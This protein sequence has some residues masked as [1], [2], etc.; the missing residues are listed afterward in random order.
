MH[1]QKRVNDSVLWYMGELSSRVVAESGRACDRFH[2]GKLILRA[3]MDA[4]DYVLQIDGAT[5]ESETNRSVLE[6]STRC[7]SALRNFGLEPG[8]VMVLMA[9][10]HLD[11]A[12]PFY[13]ALYLGVVVSPVDRTLTVKELHNTFNVTR[14]KIVFCQ[15]EK[16][17]DIQLTLNQLDLNAEIV[18]FDKG[19]YLCNFQQFLEKYADGTAVKDFKPTDFDPEESLAVLIPTSG[20]TG[21]PKSAA[22]SHKN[23]VITNPYLWSKYIQFPTPTR[24]FMIGSP[25]Q[26]LTAIVNFLFSPILRYTRL[27]SSQNLTL[28]HACY[29]INRFKPS[30]SVF[31]PTL[32]TTLIRPDNAV[33]CDLTCFET[34]LLGGSAVPPSLI[35]ELKILTPGT[36][37][38][39]V[40][41]MTELTSLGFHSEAG[42][43]GACG[44]P[45]G[46][47]QYRIVNT[48]T[49]KDITE[50]NTLGE[51]WVK[52][53]GIFKGYYN[54]EEATEDTFA[55]DWFKTGDIFYRDEN[56]FFYFVERAKLMLKYKANQISPVELEVV[57]RQ[58]P[59]VSDVAVAG[60]PD[61]E[62]GDLPVACVVRRPGW[63]VTAQE[64]KDVVKNNL[65]DAKQL[66]GGVI[67]VKEL[68]MTASTKV[69]RRK[70]KEM[71]LELERE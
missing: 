17:P 64:I 32:M 11:L 7:A 47:F 12:I 41:G 54:N 58:H 13:A 43:P 42:P 34:I 35:D 26:W 8:D 18:T 40:Y 2:L 24:L 21:A 29:V 15:S 27:Q 45:V 57:I 14:P 25:L 9:P 36:D 23:F 63:A 37:V 5:N 68:P 70:L 30:Y 50:P 39:N 3:M 71:V 19:D 59:G 22:C 51:L 20:T 44:K 6:R 46:C 66:R 53:P 16:A 10:N 31:S 38:C 33:Q 52:G 4:P 65:S 48:T 61:P 55:D 67:F 62:C 28:D 56:W 1:R 60:I 69:H 49:L